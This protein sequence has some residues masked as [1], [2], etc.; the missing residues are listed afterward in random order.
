[1]KKKVLAM[2]LIMA[3]TAGI[4]GC[5]ETEKAT[6]EQSAD[7]QSTGASS[8][9]G[10]SAASDMSVSSDPSEWP[11]VTVETLVVDMP[12]E[13]SI[14]KALNDYLVSI[15]AGVQ[16]KLEGFNY[17]DLS[18]NLTL[19]LTDN[20]NPLDL[21]C[22]R[23]Y[24]NLDSCVKN[25]QCISLDQYKDVYPDLWNMYPDKVLKTQQIDGTQYAIPS[26]DSYATFEDYML[27]KDVAED[28][29]V[30]DKDGQKITMDEMT[31]IMK[32]AKAAHPEFSYMINT[33][34]EPVI[35]IDS[36]GNPK[37]IGV[38]MNRGVDQKKI[39][40]LYETDEFK[41]YCKRMKEWNKAG[42]QM[43]DPLNNDLTISQYNNGV[44]AGCYVGGYSADYVKALLAYSPYDSV[45]FQLTDL[46]GTSASVLGGWMI[47]STCKH[48]D[49]AMKALY[50]M[51]TDEKV[52]RYLIL[53]VE[54]ET[55]TVDD[56]GIA[57][58]PDGVDSTTSTW[59]MTCPWYYPNQ[60]LSLPLETDMTTYYTDMLKAPEQAK[61]SSAMGFI[62][63][64]TSV[65]D[66]MAACETVVDE[67]RDALLYGLV[68]VDEYL[69]KFNA[70]LK[71]AGIDDV[72][73]EEQK[74]YDAFLAKQ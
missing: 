13:A 64:S 40:N 69:D 34:D 4:A 23:F 21:F 36:L 62:F 9:K 19:A 2:L 12:A 70:E 68:D 61:F 63:D 16:F 11:T 72:I 67:Y 43:D 45:Q 49:A 74:Q 15:N 57:R 59:N 20:D 60:C 44:A 58:Y 18:T 47:S 8:A 27:R 29:G 5:G 24:S 73:A 32:K 66:Q 38:L 1:M 33:N 39:V 37:W 30:A 17:G 10:Q 6:G 28:I 3:M 26:V 71:N 14:T 35:G 31:D 56:K 53:G 41:E 52:A 50:L 65:Y 46:V 48:P 54:G 22:W 7:T 25:E 42:L 51:A 55:Y